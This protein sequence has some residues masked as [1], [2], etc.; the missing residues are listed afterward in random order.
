[1]TIKEKFSKDRIET[2]LR[3]KINLKFGENH[4]IKLALFKAIS[5][6][7]DEWYNW[8]ANLILIDSNYNEVDQNINVSDLVPDQED[9]YQ[10]SEESNNHRDYLDIEDITI[11]F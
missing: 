1:M 4:N 2:V 10:F 9:E 6:Y 8:D 5:N 11:K 3:Q 7:D